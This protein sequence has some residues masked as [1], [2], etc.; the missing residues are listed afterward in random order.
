MTEV[1]FVTVSLSEASVVVL[2][3]A[4]VREDERD[5]MEIDVRP[6]VEGSEVNVDVDVSKV[7]DSADAVV[8][9]EIGRQGPANAG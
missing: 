6:V 1:S 2:S 5:T 9:R 3:P 8:D 4:K 7:E